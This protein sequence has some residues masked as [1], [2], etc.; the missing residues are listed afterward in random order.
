MLKSLVKKQLFE[1]NRS[2]FY[3]QKK[4]KLRTKSSSVAFIIL[5]ALLMVVVLGGMFAGLS[6]MLCAPL[7]DEG[8][9]WLYMDIMVLVAVMLGVFGS[10]FNTYSSLYKAKDNDMLLSLPI[11]TRYVLI[12][13]L[14][15]VYLMGL[16]FSAVVMLPAVIVYFIVAQPG[17]SGIVGS[18]VLTLL[19]SL[20]VFTLSCLLGWI[21]ARVSVH[22]KSKSIVVV[23]LSLLFLGLY[24]FVCFNAYELIQELIINALT[25]GEKLKSSA[26]VLYLIGQ[27][28]TGD[29]GAIAVITLSVL[30]LFALTYYILDRSFL[31]IATAS[32]K[33]ANRK[34]A[35]S[36]AKMRSAGSALLSREFSHL[37]SS[38]TYMLNCCL[39]APLM[40]IA[41]VFVLI[42]RADLLMLSQMLDF[43]PEFLPVMMGI[44]VCVI[45]S[46]N[47]L[48][49]PSVSLEGKS[50]WLAQSLPVEPKQV[51]R[52]KMRMSLL[53]TGIPTLLSCACIMFALRADLLTAAIC[54]VAA[55]VFVFAVSA[56]GLIMNLRRPQ[57]SWQSETVP[58][59]QSIVVLIS[60]FVGWLIAALIGVGYFLLCKTL[61]AS[62]YLALVCLVLIALSLVQQR[63]LDTKGSEIFR[64]L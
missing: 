3:D 48:T 34:T 31:K 2:F 17:V 19:V 50:I 14:L 55:L 13:R 11:P 18:I 64:F 12:S 33:S 39:G 37:L 56:F 44:A 9:T 60:M 28:G 35:S 41:A 6:L 32:G 30:I 43:P 38:P 40:L 54:T 36:A 58:V 63:W 57:L 1:L 62:L 22:V 47:V 53:A 42:E 10:V 52:A 16:M 7:A 45:A 15:G 24:Y 23:I 25:V 8:L 27:S 20:F 5:Y 59:K 29:W 21:V 51:L 61:P 26:Y 49:A 46:M 4:G